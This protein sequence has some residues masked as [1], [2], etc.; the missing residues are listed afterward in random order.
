MT[1][2]TL[3]LATL[4]LSVLLPW[5][6]VANG[7]AFLAEF[8]IP[9]GIVYAVKYDIQAQVVYIGGD[10]TEVDGQPR[11]HLASI[12]VLSGTLTSW[13]PNVNGV[14]RAI[15]VGWDTLYVGGDFSMVGSTVRNQLA[16]FAFPSGSLTPWNP[17]ANGPVRTLD[18]Q[19][20][21]AYVGGDFNTMGGVGMPGVGGIS[22][23]GTGNPTSCIPSDCSD[24]VR[25][26]RIHGSVLWVGG[27]FIQI[28][29]SP[30]NHLAALN[31]ISG[32]TTSWDPDADGDVFGISEGSGTDVHIAGSFQNV[33]GQ[34]RKGFAA[35]SK[36]SANATSWDANC[37][38]IG[39]CITANSWVLFVGGEFDHCGGT[40][41][42]GFAAVR[43]SDGVASTWDPA[44]GNGPDPVV[45]HCVSV[46][47][48]GMYYVFAGGD[49]Q[50]VGGTLHPYFAAWAGQF[51]GLQETDAIKMLIASPNPCTG[52]LRLQLGDPKAALVE[53]RN[54]FGIEVRTFNFK[55]NINLRDL[56]GGLYTVSVLDRTGTTL[57]RTRI[58]LAQ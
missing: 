43:L 27:D 15:Q 54:I 17:N 23:T 49:F 1:R 5:F 13:N 46:R 31:Y 57:A 35:L 16:C 41:R 33:G 4:L 24:R 32:G 37:D 56:P 38:G 36:S 25:A 55:H 22:T 48:T 34:F 47:G 29:G 28:G 39:R 3:R 30:R 21:T 2:F 44:L 45:V 12:D 9:N 40:S 58:V 6:Q 50:T 19:G 8:P 11:N 53:V 20:N 51:T 26:L 7:Q 18:V 52:E 14:V 10:F 42:N